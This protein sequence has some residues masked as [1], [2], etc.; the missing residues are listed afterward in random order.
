M[1]HRLKESAILV[2]ALIYSLFPALL[3]KHRRV[4]IYY[5]S[6][7]GKD[8]ESFSKQMKYLAASCHV[9]KISEIMTVQAAPKSSVVAI[10]FDDAFVS[11]WDNG[12]PVLRKYD[13]PAAFFV[14]AGNLGRRPEW[15]MD[16]DYSDMNETVMTEQQI[17][18]LD[19]QGYEIFSHTVSHPVLT[20]I[21]DD[22]LRVELLES[23]QKLETIAGHEVTGVSYPH[24][25]QNEKVCRSARAVG[26][27][28]GFTIEPR[29]VDKKT[30]DLRIGR[31]EVSASDSI[32]KFRL[33]ARGA[34][35]VVHYLRTIKR[36]LLR[37]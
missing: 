34:Y 18:K 27:K 33:K 17:A 9:V 21:E 29:I 4:V 36:L 26:Y 6:V 11:V 15:F 1:L 14:P 28:W 16:D 10:T 2:V 22:K 13:L 23:R 31:V 19:Q 20:E 32:L 3:R 8:V 12:L 35:Q 25:A 5:H 7:P 37:N 30:D 24:G